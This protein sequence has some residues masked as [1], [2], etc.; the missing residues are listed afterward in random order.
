MRVFI[1]ADMEGITGIVHRDQLMPDGK[2]WPAGRALM[3]GDVNAAI[4][5]VLDEAPDASF[6][7]NDG[8]AVMRNVLL[9]ELHDRAELVIGP[10]TVENKPL[11]QATGIEDGFDLLLLIGHHTMAGTPGGLLSHTWSGRVVENFRLNGQ[12]IGEIALNSAIAGT[13][14]VP[15]GLVTGTDRLGE[16]VAATLPGDVVHVAVK[17]TLGPTAALCRTPRVARAAIREGA[18]EAVRRLRDGRL[19]PLVPRPPVIME[20]DTYRREMAT[21]ALRAGTVERVGES[22]LRV[23]APDAAAAA[24]AM[25]AAVAR[26]H[27]E[28]GSWLQ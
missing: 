21:K 15:P 26:A 22:T 24:R 3:T 13:F 6:V 9:E 10:A 27:D 20:V 12:R 18:A 5:G 16:E 19:T 25:W 14:G 8:H 4:E 23:E 1:S 28:I 2:T 7:V 11:C 17:R